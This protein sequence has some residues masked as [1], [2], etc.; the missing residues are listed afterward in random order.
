MQSNGECG[1]EVKNREQ[2]GWIGWRRMSGV[3]C[4]WRVPS[5]V[6]GEV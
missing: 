5:R 6:K 2:A 4:D 3:V 1:R